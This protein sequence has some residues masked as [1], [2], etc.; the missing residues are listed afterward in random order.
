VLQKKIQAIQGNKAESL[1]SLHAPLINIQSN[2]DGSYSP[3]KY[4][5]V[6]YLIELEKVDT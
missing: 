5:K 3:L 1:F 6:G 2:N 4:K